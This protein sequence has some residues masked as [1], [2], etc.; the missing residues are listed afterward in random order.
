MDLEQIIE[1]YN[2]LRIRAL[3]LAKEKPELLGEF[4]W[5]RNAIQDEEVTLHFL[6]DNIALSGHTFTTQTMSS[7]WF[8]FEVP[9]SELD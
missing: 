3:Q 2:I 8:W 1:E 9:L 6:D 7:E 4:A 5:L